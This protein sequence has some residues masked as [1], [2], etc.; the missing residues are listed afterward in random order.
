MSWLELLLGRLIVVDQREARTPSST[1]HRLET[2]GDHTVLVRLVHS[3]QLLSEVGLGDI[4]AGWV[5][6]VDDEL[7]AGEETVGDELAGPEG[8][9][10]IGVDLSETE[11]AIWH[12]SARLVIHRN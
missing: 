4:S 3:G 1:K 6:D 12:L 8:Y 7:T 10:G 9:W 2:E 5:E 11:S